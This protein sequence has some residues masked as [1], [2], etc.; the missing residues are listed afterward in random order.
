M[1][2]TVRHVMKL[3]MFLVSIILRNVMA[4][5]IAFLIVV[6]TLL[7][8]HQPAEAQICYSYD[9]LG[10]LVGVIDQQGEAA[11][12]RYDSVGNILQIERH[13]AAAPVGIVLIDPPAGLAGSQVEILGRGFST[14]AGQNQ[15]TLNGLSANVLLATPCRLTVEVPT[16]ASTGLINVTTP[17]GSAVSSNSFIVFTI[18]IGATVPVQI[19]GTSQQ[20][21]A[22][23]A[24][25]SDPRLVWS[26]N[27]I[28]GG[29]AGIGT[30]T[31]TGLYTAPAAEP[32]TSLFTIRAE[33]VGCRGLFAERT[34]AI[35]GLP[36]TTVAKPPVSVEIL[37]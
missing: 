14:V 26:V 1:D 21:T 37:P 23:I 6:I 22:T 28:V 9:G 34:V 11:V 35:M 17:F 18:S 13:I 12:Y 8:L 15:V 33:S 3:E 10:R 27:G 2:R 16:G 32:L 5:L 25:C 31:Q 20:F 29:N 36:N 7:L 24:G 30:I 4:K 19:I